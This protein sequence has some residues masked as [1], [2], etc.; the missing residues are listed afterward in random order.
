MTDQRLTGWPGDPVEPPSLEAIREAVD[1]LAGSIVRTPIV[2]LLSNDGDTGVY[3]KPEVLQP[4]GSFK[5][6]GV[7]NWALSLSAQEAAKG[8]STTSAGNTAQAV[9]YMAR[10]LGVTSRSLVPESLHTGKRSA[11]EAYGTE[12]VGVSMTDL[13]IY[14]FEERWREEPY[15]YLNP[16]GEPLMIAGHG[17]IGV[18]IHDDLAEVESVFVPVGGGALIAGVAAALKA[19]SPRVRVYAVQAEV[20]SALAAA[21]DAEA[22]VWIEWRDT[23]VEGASTP[24]ITHNMY[25]MLRALIDEVVLVSEAEVRTAMRRLALNDKLVTEGAGAASVAAALKTPQDERGRSVAVIS[26]GS[27]DP[28][29]FAEVVAPA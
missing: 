11:I 28:V 6:R 3:L 7:G 10:Q 20:N 14:M 24:V 27:V 25:P 21:F 22:P 13:M 1:R 12:L 29:L 5:V 9:G 4:I 19:L 18:E 23:I 17:T 2:P 26:G 16:W 15:C 8:L